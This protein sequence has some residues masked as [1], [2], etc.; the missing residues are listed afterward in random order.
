M[1]ESNK[2]PKPKA[3]IETAE[4]KPSLKPEESFQPKAE[5]K[6]NQK[7]KFEKLNKGPK[8]QNNFR[9]PASKLAFKNKASK[10]R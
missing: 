2:K 10:G 7:N 5:P 9:N 3:A 8:F 6:F 4:K 1:P